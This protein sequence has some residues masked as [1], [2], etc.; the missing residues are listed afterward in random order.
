MKRPELPA[1]ALIILIPVV[2][3]IHSCK[4]VREPAF[5]GDWEFEEQVVAGGITYNTSRTLNLSSSTFK[6]VYIISRQGSDKITSIIGLKGDLII[7]HS[8]LVFALKELGTCVKDDL[9]FCT[10]VVMWYGDGS[11]YWNDNVMFFKTS[12][13]GEFETAGASLHLSRDLNDDGDFDDPG[14]DILYN[15]IIT[16]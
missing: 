7:N 1:L 15:K 12:V 6:E 3:L 2:I 9:D 10:D 11:Q 14:E 13:Y 4:K 8:N 16:P 5:V